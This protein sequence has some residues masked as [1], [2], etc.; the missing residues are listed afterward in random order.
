MLYVKS[1]KHAVFPAKGIALSI[2][3]YQKTANV[4]L[5]IRK[6]VVMVIE[7]GRAMR[8]FAFKTFGWEIRL[9]GKIEVGQTVAYG[10]ERESISTSSYK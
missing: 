4:L 6:F 1:A 9:L 7:V 5:L 2:D 8:T 3:R 10:G